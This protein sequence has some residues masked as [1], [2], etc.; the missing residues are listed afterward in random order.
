MNNL[1]FLVYLA[2]MSIFFLLERQRIAQRREIIIA[3]LRLGKEIPAAQPRLRVLESLLNIVLGAP[4]AGF[5]LMAGAGALEARTAASAYFSGMI[6]MAAVVLATGMTL[7]LLGGM[8][9]VQ[10]VRSRASS[11]SPGSAL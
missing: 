1:M 2:G 10:N 4:L 5:G 8:A 6:T 7:V 11:A 3:C 9:I